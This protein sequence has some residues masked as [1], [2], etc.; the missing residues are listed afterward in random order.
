MKIHKI[1]LFSVMAFS[2]VLSACTPT[3]TDDTMMDKP[4]A[5]MMEEH[6]RR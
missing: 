1:L 4:T 6:L 3:K 2:L 5:A